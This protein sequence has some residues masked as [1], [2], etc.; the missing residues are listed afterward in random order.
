MR[1]RGEQKDRNSKPWRDIRF[2]GGLHVGDSRIWTGV[3]G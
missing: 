3:V 1:S 2:G